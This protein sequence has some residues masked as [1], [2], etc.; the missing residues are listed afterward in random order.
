MIREAR[1]LINER[2]P[3]CELCVD[4]G[5]RNHNLEALLKEDIDVMVAST[6]IFGHEKGITAGVHDF[7]AALDQAE[8]NV[9]AE[10]EVEPA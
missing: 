8:K 10:A 1:Q 6:N 9:A 5:I 3:N 4:G 7:R 2:N